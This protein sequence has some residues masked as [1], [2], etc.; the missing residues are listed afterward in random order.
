MPLAVSN[1]R[2]F[3]SSSLEPIFLVHFLNLSNLQ[4]ET[5]DLL[6]K[7]F[8]VIHRFRITHFANLSVGR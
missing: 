8:N 4:T 3:A 2:L 7:N 5:P 1:L 6:P